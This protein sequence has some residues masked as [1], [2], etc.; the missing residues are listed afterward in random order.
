VRAARAAIAAAA[1]GVL[2]GCA[3]TPEDDGLLASTPIV[4]ALDRET[5]DVVPV[6]RFSQLSP[7]DPLPDGWARWGANSGKPPTV[8]R[9]VSNG[10]RTALEAY[11]ELGAT[12]LYRQIRV[13]PHRQPILEWSWRVEGLIPEADVRFA[14]KDDSAA[15]IVVSFHGDPAKLDFEDRTQLR[16]V[17]AITGDRLPYAILMYVWA[18][19]V[20]VGTVVQHP[21]IG[22]IK[23]IVVESGTKHLGQ[24]IPYRRNLVED[25]RRAFGEDPGDLVSVGVLTDSDNVQHIAHGWYGDITLRAP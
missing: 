7:G 8:Y 21:H 10:G 3:T 23:I 18:N 22:R 9:I 12:G 13:D 25:F 14:R 24:W 5:A 17:K 6:A 11:A 1:L 16:L 15:R 2:A 4:R 19:D 20:P